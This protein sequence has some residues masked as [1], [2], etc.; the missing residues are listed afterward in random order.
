MSG[1]PGRGA[2]C[3]RAC[4]RTCVR[5]W[6]CAC[7]SA[8]AYI[9][10]KYWMVWEKCPAVW[11]TCPAVWEKCPAVWGIDAR[12]SNILSFRRGPGNFTPFPRVGPSAYKYWMVSK[13]V[14]RPGGG[15]GCRPKFSSVKIDGW[16]LQDVQRSGE[17]GQ[18]MCGHACVRSCVSVCV[19]I[20]PSKCWVVTQKCPAVQEICLAVQGSGARPSKFVPFWSV[21][22]W[23]IKTGPRFQTQIL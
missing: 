5:A 1:G 21:S 11:E 2:T 18:A 4:V 16:L 10:P 15:V 8:C 22:G 23:K 19:P 7:V 20:F 3:G 13:N 17:G 6:V 12:P 9:S 14:Q